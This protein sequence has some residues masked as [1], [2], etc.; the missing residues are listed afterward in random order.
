MERNLLV[1]GERVNSTRKGIQEALQKRDEAFITEEVKAQIEG[2]AH[3]IDLNAATLMEGEIECLKWLVPLVQEVADVPICLDS[4]NPKAMEEILP[5]CEKKPIVNSITGESERYESLIPIIKEHKPKVIALTI[6]DSGMPSTA[7]DRVRI[8]TDLIQKLTADGVSIE[9]I[10]VDPVV[11]PVST[12]VSSGKAV[13]D[14]IET[15]MEKFPG[16]HTVCGLSNVSFGLPKRKQINQIF[17]VLALSK[18]LDAVILDPCDKRM[19]ANLITTLML[20][21][22]DEFCMNYINACKEGKIEVA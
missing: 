1:I 17:L 15:I 16:V 22:E 18:G 2:G 7:E 4:P 8:A 20:L 10:Y 13:L 14:A 5:L 12:D 21:G 3:V 19:M 11:T 6:D 9:D